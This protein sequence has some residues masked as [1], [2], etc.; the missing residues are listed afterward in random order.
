MR[1]FALYRAFAAARAS[2]LFRR[3]AAF[4]W[5]V[6][7]FAA[8]SSALAARR[9]ASA[10]ASAPPETAVRAALTAVRA[11]ER[12]SVIIAVRRAVWRMRLSVERFLFLVGAA[13]SERL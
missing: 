3:A 13:I 8:R 1:F 11:A 9:T 2:R 5:I 7:R 6:P 4:R 12:R 10:A